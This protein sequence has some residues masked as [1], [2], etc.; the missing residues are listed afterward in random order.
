MLG[1]FI[2]MKSCFNQKYL[3]ILSEG[4][5]SFNQADIK[6]CTILIMRY[7]GKYITL[8]YEKGKYLSCNT[9][10]AIEL[11][12]KKIVGENERFE[13]EW[14]DENLFALK[15]CNGFYLSVQKDEKIETNQKN[16]GVN[17]QFSMTLQKKETILEFLNLV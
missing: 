12:E 7:V 4:K 13:I 11:I 16:V 2:A 17:E 3:S 10:G 9:Y 15:A 5:I 8:Q 1:H 6:K 14:L